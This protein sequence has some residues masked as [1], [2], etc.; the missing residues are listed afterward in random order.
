MC[1][2]KKEDPTM[3]NYFNSSIKEVLQ[4]LKQLL[5]IDHHFLYLIKYNLVCKLHQCKHSRKEIII[6]LT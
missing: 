3:V 4:C 1:K 2:L 6:N 5:G